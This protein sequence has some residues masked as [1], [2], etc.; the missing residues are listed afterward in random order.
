MVVVRKF[1]NG[2]WKSIYGITFDY[3]DEIFLTKEE[4]Q[5]LFKKLK[6]VRV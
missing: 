6:G 5:E 2:M 1:D 3:H 4:V